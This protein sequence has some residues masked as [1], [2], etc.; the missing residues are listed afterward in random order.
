MTRIKILLV[1][2]LMFC[3][4]N[5]QAIEGILLATTDYTFQDK[6][7]K[8]VSASVPQIMSTK[9]IYRGQNMYV[10]IIVGDFDLNE[11]KEANITYDI[12]ITN[13]KR[14]E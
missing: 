3:F 8:T 13:P 6:W 10:A 1:I 7:Y 12:V 2:H 14:K 9:E 11:K 4:C 5:L